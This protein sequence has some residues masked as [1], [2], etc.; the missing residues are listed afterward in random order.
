MQSEG[1]HQILNILNLYLVAV[2][3]RKSLMNL[4]PVLFNNKSIYH[5]EI[6]IGKIDNDIGELIIVVRC[7]LWILVNYKMFTQELISI[8]SNIAYFHNQ[9]DEIT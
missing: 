8:K 1:H 4:F 7:K 3:H 2:G 9:Y 6:T 5:L